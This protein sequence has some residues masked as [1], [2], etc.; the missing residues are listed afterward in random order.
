[1][2]MRERIFLHI[3]TKEFA[4]NIGRNGSMADDASM[5]LLCILPTFHESSLLRTDTGRDLACWDRESTRS[6]Y[7][8]SLYDKL[9][10]PTTVPP[11]TIKIF[12]KIC[13]QSSNT[14][15]I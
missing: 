4:R 10:Y 3:S 2:G 5:M 9:V 13:K 15:P 14:I 8:R 11:L 1:M 6:K 12:K 7:I